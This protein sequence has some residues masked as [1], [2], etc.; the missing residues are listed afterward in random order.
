MYMKTI[1]IAIFIASTDCISLR[2]A[3]DFKLCDDVV[4]TGIVSNVFVSECASLPCTFRRGQNYSI[5]IDF[6]N[7][8]GT[9]I[10]TA[11]VYGIILGIPV[12]W[13]GLDRDGCNHMIIGGCPMHVGDY[14]TYG[15]AMPVDTLLPP[16]EATLRW[17]IK[18]DDGREIFCFEIP[19][20][21]V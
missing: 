12:P 7:N 21:L 10:L 11:E 17:L 6:E 19:V 15:M 8:R 2:N 9:E 14:V 18:G 5:E 4:P 13:P 16:V 3:V 1:L 20:R